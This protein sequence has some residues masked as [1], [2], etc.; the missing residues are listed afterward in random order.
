ML[1]FQDA[2]FSLS[3]A[4]EIWQP[5]QLD[6]WGVDGVV[7]RSRFSKGSSLANTIKV[8]EC[9]FDLIE[10]ISYHVEHEFSGVVVKCV[11]SLYC[12]EENDSFTG[13]DGPVYPAKGWEPEYWLRSLLED[14]A[15]SINAIVI[16]SDEDN[17]FNIVCDMPFVSRP[18]SLVTSRFPLSIKLKE[19]LHIHGV[20]FEDGDGVV[21][22]V[23]SNDTFEPVVSSMIC[24]WISDVIYDESEMTKIAL[25]Q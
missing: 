21:T 18:L 17:D 2:V 8:L 6:V 22:I 19:G 25:R 15:L 14:V 16:I 9:D 1:C 23:T 11:I 3:K 4:L 13:I 12:C 20:K 10:R 24:E 7:S 5:N